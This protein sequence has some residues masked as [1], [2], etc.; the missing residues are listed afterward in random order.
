MKNYKI[1]II[2]TY[3][4]RENTIEECI[5]SILN[6]YIRNW[7][8]ICVN[9][10]STDKSENIVLKYENYDERIK[11]V[12]L[13]KKNDV[14][15]AKLKGFGIASGEF[16]YFIDG[17]SPVSQNFADDIFEY[18]FRE[19]KISDN[20]I[21]K[22]N[23]IENNEDIVEIV[24]DTLDW[25][26]SDLNDEILK[27]GDDLKSENKEFEQSMIN[28]IQDKTYGIIS[29][30]NQLEK[31]F[32]EKDYEYKCFIDQEIKNICLN[33]E[34]A[35]KALYEKINQ[36]YSDIS[37]VYDYINS[38]INKKGFEIN[39]VYDE[40]TK[41][42]HYTESLIDSKINDTQIIAENLPE[43]LTEKFN[44]LQKEIILRHLS[45]KRIT[46]IRFDEVDSRIKA[47]N[48]EEAQPGLTSPE[49]FDVKKIIDENIN[50]VYNA[51]NKFTSD[52]Y[53]EL[54]ELYKDINEKINKQREE[55]KYL[56]EKRLTEIKEELLIELTSKTEN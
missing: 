9:N 26:I 16:V 23:F 53:S 2:L 52:F 33:N 28:T 31:I 29:R 54:K 49:F 19:N 50:N 56:L 44:E 14:N 8:L 45:L 47:L 3:H 18:P 36:I 24:N 41:N 43:S 48:P 7:E 1:S 37:K 25:R 11:L 10:G 5:K 27:I 34:S 32:F 13:P 40:I 35:N 30:F 12:N 42:Y 21:Y 20:K 38:E 51:L 6:L 46:D 39:K 15:I 4:N 22:K 17:S 55:E